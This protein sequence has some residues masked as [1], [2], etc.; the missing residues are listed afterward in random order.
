MRTFYIPDSQR[1]GRQAGLAIGFSETLRQKERWEE[2]YQ[3]G[4][5]YIFG[6]RTITWVQNR[7]YNLTRNL[8]IEYICQK[9]IISSKIQPGTSRR[10]KHP[11]CWKCLIRK[12]E[13]GKILDKLDRMKLVERYQHGQMQTSLTY[14]RARKGGCR[15]GFLW[16]VHT[17]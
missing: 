16:N 15:S 11:L 9:M 5:R 4:I 17:S 6:K 13:R 10:M 14:H 3:W 7:H 1:D 2:R 12:V 8:V